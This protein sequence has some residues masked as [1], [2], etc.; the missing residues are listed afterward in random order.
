MYPKFL[1][2]SLALA[3]PAMAFPFR[4]GAQDVTVTPLEWVNPKDAPDELPMENHPLRPHFPADLRGIADPGYVVL[5]IFTSEKGK[6]L[7]L[8]PFGTLPGYENAVSNETRNWTLK[9]GRR[10]GNAVNTF[11]RTLVVFNPASADAARPS[12]TPRLL[13]AR[14]VV[15]PARRPPR[16]SHTA[17]PAKVVWANV[18]LDASGTPIGVSEAPPEVSALLDLAVHDFRFAPARRDGVAVAARLRVPFILVPYASEPDAD[19][20]MVPPR[21]VRQTRPI[22]PMEMR[23]SGMRGEVVVDFVVDLEGRVTQAFVARSMNPAFDEPALEAVRSWRFEPGRKGKIPVNT[24][25]QVPVFF[26]LEGEWEGGDTGVSIDTKTSQSDLPP[27][28]RYDVPPKP[29]G[30]V[31]PVYPYGPLRDGL[32]GEATVRF[33]ISETGRVIFS[34]VL[35]ATH[36]DF[37]AATVAMVEQ[38]VFEPGL[39]DG[40]PTRTVFSFTQKFAPADGDLVPREV[41]SLLALERKH[42]E[43]IVS[44]ALLD[45]RPKPISTRPPIFPAS[46]RGRFERGE[47]TIEFVIDDEGRARLPRIVSASDPAFGWAALQSV[48]VWRFEPAANKGRHVATRVRVPFEFSETPAAPPTK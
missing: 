8:H 31:L 18:A 46:A 4:L 37:G 42:P 41:D 21:A 32:K 14:T 13:H 33:V 12:A 16:G 43:R 27:E 28:F 30:R 2:L 23:R 11:T 29:R 19:G 9:P 44:A 1:K 48:S 5:E 25:L 10:K 45:A 39:K 24:H 15:D 47:A 17:V 6:C 34:K 40:H 7:S 3:L 22:Y 38:W 20:T 35:D 36:P 26:Q